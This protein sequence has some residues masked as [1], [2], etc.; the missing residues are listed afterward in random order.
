MLSRPHGTIGLDRLRQPIASITYI[1]VVW[2]LNIVH[3]SSGD[4]ILRRGGALPSALKTNPAP[5][6]TEPGFLF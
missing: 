2:L 3:P 4:P 5:L 1:E 6:A